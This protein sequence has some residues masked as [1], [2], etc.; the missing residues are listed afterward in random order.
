[1]AGRDGDAPLDAAFVVEWIRELAGQIREQRDYLT[2]LDAAIGD[3]DHGINMDRGL[4]EAVSI[5]PRAEGR[6]PGEVLQAVGRTIINTVGGAAGPLFGGGLRSAGRRLGEQSTFDAEDLLAAMR[7]GLESIQALGAASVG[8]KTIVDAYV[9]ALEAFE[10]ELRAG[11]DLAS[12][13]TRAREA[14]EEGMRSTIPL[15]ARKGRASY[16]GPRSV[17]HQD[18]GAT[19]TALLF[20]ALERTARA[21]LAVTEERP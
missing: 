2:Q 11:R 3:A 10:R 12:A 19:S 5:V 4:T 8:D 7:A 20:V 17:G 15:Q 18:P 16:L 21:R 9:P 13:A 1:M 14:A 6:S